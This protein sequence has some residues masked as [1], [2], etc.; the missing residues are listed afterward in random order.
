MQY[1]VLAYGMYSINSYIYSQLFD[2]EVT[3]PS[4]PRYPLV[5]NQHLY[6]LSTLE[7]RKKFMEN[8]VNY[9]FNQPLAKPV[10]PLQ[11]AVLGPPKSGKT[12]SELVEYI[13][14]LRL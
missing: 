8:P 1:A 4:F 2:G 9:V 13:V 14:I 11:I 5:Y 12:T 3:Q 10:V 7:S 6:F